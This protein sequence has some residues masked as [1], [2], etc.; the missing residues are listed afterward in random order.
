M[1]APSHTT[2]HVAPLRQSA[3]PWSPSVN[4]HVAPSQ[5][6]SASRPVRAVQSAPVWQLTVEFGPLAVTSHELSVAQ[7]TPV[8]SRVLVTSHRLPAPQ[9]SAQAAAPAASQSS[10][11]LAPASHAQE[12]AVQAQAGPGHALAGASQPAAMKS[13]PDQT[14]TRTSSRM[15]FSSRSGASGEPAR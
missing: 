9:S 7:V 14:I 15:S 13:T 3:S 12:D 1:Q 8:S 4:V 2:V 10:V 11:Q 5:R 6:A